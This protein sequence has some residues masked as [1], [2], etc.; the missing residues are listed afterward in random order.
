MGLFYC[1]LNMLCVILIL[2]FVEICFVA[3]NTVGFSKC[4]RWTWSVYSLVFVYL[5]IKLVQL[6][7]H[8]SPFCLLELP[9]GVRG[10]VTYC[11]EFTNLLIF[12]FPTTFCLMYIWGS[13]FRQLHTHLQNGSVQFNR[14]VVSDSLQPHESQH[15]RP[16]LSITNSASQW[17]TSLIIGQ[18]PL[19]FLVMI[20]ALRSTL[21]KLNFC[22]LTSFWVI[23]T[24]YVSFYRYQLGFGGRPQNHSSFVSWKKKKGF[25]IK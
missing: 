18:Q 12:P 21:S 9:I 17:I 10:S 5:L 2:V 4:S 6:V 3:E 13:V 8:S 19:V 23:F 22:P 15:A 16:S 7:L 11:G 1:S 25:I 24:G 14:S 20:C